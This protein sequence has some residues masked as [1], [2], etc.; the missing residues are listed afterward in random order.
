MKPEYLD[1]LACP[2]CGSIHLRLVP[3]K[4]DSTNR[5]ESG[6]ISCVDCESEYA[7]ANYIPRFCSI[8][9]YAD[10]FGPQWRA[11]AK[12]QLDDDVG[13]E[14]TI[15]FDSEIGWQHADLTG[16]TAI[17]FGS[18]AGRFVDIVSKR[19]AKLVVGLDATDA[20][21]ASQESLQHRDNVLFV[22]GDIFSPPI[23]RDSFDFGYTIGVLHH[24]PDPEGGFRKLLSVVAPTGN[25]AVSV[26]EV[27]NYA[28]P[29]RDSLKV[30]TLELLW[31]LN[32]WRCEVF[33]AITTRLPTTVFLAYCKTVVPI[34]H[35]VNKI[36][37]LRYLRYF[38]PSTCYKNLPATWSMVDTHD[39]YATEIVH[40]YRGKDIFQ[41]FLREGLTN[42]ILRNSRAGWVS[43]TGALAPFEVRTKNRVSLNQ[44]KA[45]GD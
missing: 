43:I 3:S 24:T 16:K 20:V 14:S 6:L 4:I 44:P 35:L 37:V 17:E 31:A 12:T 29:N 33:R 10:S 19:G 18:G 2:S 34:L 9:P 26:Y 36:P 25:V 13:R 30:V 7:I 40:R 32:T 45:P 11:F 23:R 41:W 38:L 22:Q 15:R 5:I 28:R 8:T 27:S 21:D 39:T 42:I 1:L